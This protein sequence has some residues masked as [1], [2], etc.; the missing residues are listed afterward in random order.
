MLVKKPSN[1][2]IELLKALEFEL[3][4]ENMSIKLGNVKKS[5]VDDHIELVLSGM[6]F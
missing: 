1:K 6:L 4:T 3:L 5:E 2:F